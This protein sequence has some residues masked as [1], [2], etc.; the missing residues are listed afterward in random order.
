MQTMAAKK[1]PAKK[2]VGSEKPTTG[3]SAAK[4]VARKAGPS[5]KPAAKRMGRP[6]RSESGEAATLTLVLRLTASERGRLDDAAER[7]GKRVSDF[8]RDAALSYCKKT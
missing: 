3:K 2:S 4:G 8:V 6:A 5:K 1:T 7:A